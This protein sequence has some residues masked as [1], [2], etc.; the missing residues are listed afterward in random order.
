VAA[1]VVA[2]NRSGRVIVNAGTK[3]FA[4]D[5]GTPV[6]VRGVPL[7]AAY[8]FMGDEHGAVD[9]SSESTPP[10]GQ[11]IELLTSHCDPTVNL[12]QRYQVARGDTVV[13][14]WP[15]LARGY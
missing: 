15:I 7:G 6:P 2:A 11:T 9:F 10:L 12:F 8:R 14:E 13:D 4:T 5:S 3:A 1:S